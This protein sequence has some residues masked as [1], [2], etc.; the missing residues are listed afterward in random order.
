MVPRVVRIS[1]PT[2]EN[3]PSPFS[4]SPL[5]PSPFSLP[6]PCPENVSVG[7]PGRSLYLN[8]VE[9]IQHATHR[10]YTSIGT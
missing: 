2:L 8:P 3:P 7:A 9:N 4:P 5:P 6:H 10:E 1:I